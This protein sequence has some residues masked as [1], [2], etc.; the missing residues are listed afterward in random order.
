MNKL[1]AIGDVHGCIDNLDE[2]MS[3]IKIDQDRDTLVFIG[4]YIDRGPNS[5]AVVNS[6]IEIRK[7]IRNV[8]CLLGNHEQMLLEYHLNKI[9]EEKFFMNGGNVTA[10]SYG[11]TRTPSGVRINIPDSHIK[12]FHSLQLSYEQD[13]FIFV[14]AGLRPGIP[15]PQQNI[16]DMLCIRDEFIDKP[17]QFGKTVVFGHTPFKQPL[18]DQY[19]IGIDTGAA[20]GGKLTCVELME[21]KIYQTCLPCKKAGCCVA[22][23]SS[24]AFAGAGLLQ[25][26]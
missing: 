7:K 3:V 11:L 26:A 24:P 23:H 20:Y 9:N 18:I 19:K 4:D 6:V 22:P 15:L 1:F 12:F 2:M 5:R 8:V 25:R 10:F 16:K 21:M 17:H 13:N 14:H